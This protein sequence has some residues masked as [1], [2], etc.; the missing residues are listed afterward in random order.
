MAFDGVVIAGLVS[1]FKKRLVGGRIYKIYQP[2]VDEICLVI[3]NRI[4]D[5]NVTER[6]VLSVDAS[7]PIM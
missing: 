6:L 3:K 5:C 4:D 2:E 7:L 1:E